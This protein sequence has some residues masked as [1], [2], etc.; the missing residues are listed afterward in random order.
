MAIGW[1]VGGWLG[2][3]QAVAAITIE[4]DGAWRHVGNACR[5]S[6]PMIVDH[7]VLA[8]LR[9]AWPEAPA[10]VLETHRTVIAIDAPL[11]FPAAFTRLLAGEHPERIHWSKE[12]ENPLAYRACDRYLAAEH[13]KKPLSASFDKLG[14]NAT[15]AMLMTRRWGQREGFRVLPF[16]ASTDG[17]RE[18]IEAYPALLKREGVVVDR[19]RELLPTGLADATDEQDAAIC[20]VVALAHLGATDARVPPLVGP[21]DDSMLDGWIYA[22]AREWVDAGQRADPPQD[23]AVG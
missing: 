9:V 3:K 8:L 18:L 16:D 21:L 5:F 2:T 19:V 10:D 1:D 12:I 7:G 17:R 15:V 20:A 23:R 13:K 22:P 6:V 11:S 4:P 14:N